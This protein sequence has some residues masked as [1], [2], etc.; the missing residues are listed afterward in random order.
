MNETEDPSRFQGQDYEE[1]MNKINA[2]VCPSILYK[3]LEPNLD[4]RDE[5]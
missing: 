3:H 5:L 2:L 4:S 1:E